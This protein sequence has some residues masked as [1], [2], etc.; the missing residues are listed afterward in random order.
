L[1]EVA[2]SWKSGQ[3][4]TLVLRLRKTADFEWRVEGKAWMEGTPEPRDWLVSHAEQKQPLPGRPYISASPY[5]GT[6]LWF[7]DL[8]VARVGPG[9][10]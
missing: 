3:W 4:T 1:D 10:E 8:T 2:F 5:S 7:D 9:N 6:P